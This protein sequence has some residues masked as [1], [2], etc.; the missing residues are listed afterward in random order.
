MQAVKKMETSLQK[1]FKDLPHLPESTRTSLANI[2]PV[3]ALIAGILQIWAAY[4]LYHLV[5][6]ADR[7]NDLANSLS[8]YVTDQAA[9][10]TAMDKTV[11]YLGVAM[12][13]VE[14]II[15]LIAFP[16]L[17]KRQKAGWDLL[18]LAALLN[19][20]YAVVQIFTFNRGFGSFIMSLIGTA[21]GFYLLFEVRSKFTKTA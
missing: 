4:S 5:N 21:I 8:I 1:S 2:W 9:G 13:A 17:Q 15:M 18:F 20:A 6:W 19:V 16:K 10:P 12:L 14:G 7:L 3:L 11:I